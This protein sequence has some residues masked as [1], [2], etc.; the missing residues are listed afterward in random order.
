MREG[1]RDE[2]SSRGKEGL[3]K[4]RKVWNK[5]LRC[6]QSRGPTCL[7]P[8]H[9][10]QPPFPP[11]HLTP[12]PGQIRGC[13]P[14]L[15]LHAPTPS[16]S[17]SFELL[18]FHLH[19]PLF[20]HS[21]LFSTTTTSHHHHTSNISLTGPRHVRTF[22]LS[23]FYSILYSLF[24]ILYSIPTIPLQ[25]QTSSTFPPTPTPESIHNH[26]PLPL[27]HNHKICSS[28]PHQTLFHIYRYPVSILRIYLFLWI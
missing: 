16:S 7:P 13:R 24:P 10:L 8:S 23:L 12:L 19:F 6:P 3:R 26:I 21:S 11:P 9:V 22:H 28:S 20:I 14:V 1:D 4:W 17:Q 25:Y 15:S 5:N 27:P 2:S 18:R